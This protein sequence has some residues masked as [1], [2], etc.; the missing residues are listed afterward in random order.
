[1]QNMLFH[2]HSGLRYLV[3]LAGV[4]AFVVLLIGF[5]KRGPYKGVSRGIASA[6]MGLLHLQFVLGVVLVITGIWYGALIGH[7]FMMFLAVGAFTAMAGYAK[8]QTD[9]HK[10]HRVAL[11]GVVLTLALIAAG[12]MSIRP[13]IFASSGAPSARSAPR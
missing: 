12:I 8:R 3:L 9:D 2:A 1:M 7:M 5:V 13:G 10:A 11:A 6:F 4:L